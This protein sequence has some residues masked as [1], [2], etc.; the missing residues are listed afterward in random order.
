[1]NPE[2]MELKLKEHENRICFLKAD[3]R[4]L[5]VNIE[6]LEEKVETIRRMAR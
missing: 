6:M 3:I 1:M 5:R 4:A 2:W